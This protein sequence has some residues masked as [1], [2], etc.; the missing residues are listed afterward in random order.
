MTN[1]NNQQAGSSGLNFSDAF[2]GG[3]FPFP[4]QV[5]AEGR[6]PRAFP[7]LPE[8][9]VMRI[10]EEEAVAGRTFRLRDGRA[11]EVLHPGQVNDSD[12][13]DYLDA[14]LLIDGSELHADVELHLR[15]E[16]WLQH[17][18]HLDPNYSRVALHVCL[19]PPQ[20]PVPGP[21]L[22]VLAGQLRRSLRARWSDILT[23]PGRASRQCSGLLGQVPRVTLDAMLLLAAEERFS[24]KLRRLE[25]R[26]AVLRLQRI[27]RPGRQLLFEAVARALGYGGNQDGMQL[28]A[29][30][31]PLRRVL[32]L[33]EHR[34]ADALR[35][36]AGLTPDAEA[37][38]ASAGMSSLHALSR[39]A[40]KHKSVMPA[41]RIDHALRRLASAA[42]AIGDDGWWE[43]VRAACV[44][45]GAQTDY[46]MLIK[47]FRFIRECD[48]GLA[49][50]IDRTKEILVNAYAPWCLLCGDEEGI[51][52]AAQFGVK[53]YHHLPDAASNRS[54]RSFD[55]EIAGSALRTSGVQQ[56][57]IELYTRY[58]E[59]GEC[60]ACLVAAALSA[61]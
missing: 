4:G 7:V 43:Q 28:L 8:L 12:G 21:P 13:P 55:L 36:A 45:G 46:V 22:L 40:W 20:R 5:S 18:H 9:H 53:L 1:N 2:P 17:G 35:E 27:G 47:A 3:P 10:W 44:R 32:A 50:G 25:D 26:F 31:L 56:G 37:A 54:T 24:R 38:A 19:Y 52:E 6:Q 58:C 51:P 30:S 49:V 59:R 16:Q 48:A 33:E 14:H 23:R 61:R 29:E 15:P 39:R 11:L 57:M 42:S 34:R 60:P 41:N